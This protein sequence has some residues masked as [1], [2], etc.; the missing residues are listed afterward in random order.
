MM[1]RVLHF[2]EKPYWGVSGG[3]P[4]S[5]NPERNQRQWRM[6]FSSTD[7]DADEATGECVV[8]AVKTLKAAVAFFTTVRAMKKNGTK[9]YTVGHCCNPI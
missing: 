1:K 6:P 4:A 5:E 9:Q 8:F 2:G 7:E 3:C